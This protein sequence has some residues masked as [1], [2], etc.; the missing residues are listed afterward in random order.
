M[1]LWER[2][3]QNYALMKRYQWSFAGAFS[4]HCGVS[5]VHKNTVK[6]FASICGSTTTVK[7]LV[8]ELEPMS[9]TSCFP[10]SKAASPYPLSLELVVCGVASTR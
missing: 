10:G 6:I 8:D 3:A 2:E 5:P 7:Y 1:V 9:N 4:T